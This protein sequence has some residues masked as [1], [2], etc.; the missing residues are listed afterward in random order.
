[1]SSS[2]RNRKVLENL[3]NASEERTDVLEKQL[4]EAKLIAEEADK[5]Y[6]EAARKLA[7]TEVDLERAEARLEAAEA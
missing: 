7:I 4:T 6:D 5:K 3:N 2:T 1:M